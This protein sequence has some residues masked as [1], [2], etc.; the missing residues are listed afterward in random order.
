MN[1]LINEMISRCYAI[2]FRHP[3]PVLKKS[4]I[5]KFLTFQMATPKSFL[6]SSITKVDSRLPNIGNWPSTLSTNS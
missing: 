4:P 5:L 1:E 6:T 2:F 3:M